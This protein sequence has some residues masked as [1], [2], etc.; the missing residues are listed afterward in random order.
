MSDR[1]GQRRVSLVV[2]GVN[3]GDSK[4]QAACDAVLTSTLDVG[5]PCSGR[6]VAWRFSSLVTSLLT[7]SSKGVSH[8]FY[9]KEI[10]VSIYFPEYR[11]FYCPACGPGRA[12]SACGGP[13]A[14]R[15]RPGG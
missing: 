4:I 9:E 2:P 15:F 10:H 12:L 8:T 6:R 5:V 14:E 1:V 3:D 7:A 11:G 13:I